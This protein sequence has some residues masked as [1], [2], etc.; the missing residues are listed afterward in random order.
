M[1]CPSSSHKQSAMAKSSK[2]DK[3][4]KDLGIDA[5]TDSKHKKVI[6]DKKKDKKEK[7]DKKDK[8][9]K[10]E[11]KDKKEKHQHKDV[12]EDIPAQP[13]APPAA[14]QTATGGWNDWNKASFGGDMAQKNKFMRLLGAKKQQPSTAQP[15]SSIK[16]AIDADEGSRISNN[17]EKQFND[18]L[19]F[20]KQQQMG[21][22]GGLGFSR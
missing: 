17:L 18:G 19:Q 3:K 10:K 11:K 2:K 21:R 5:T 1:A 7:K 12:K 6:K 14:E 16:S 20:R 22:R 4:E 9:E 15:S 8:K 13:A